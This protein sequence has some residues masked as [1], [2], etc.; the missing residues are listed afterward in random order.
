MDL[1]R[2]G[3]GKLAGSC[4]QGNEDSLFIKCGEL[5]ASQEGL[6]SMDLVE[7]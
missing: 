5:S 6:S 4:E 7:T 3:K 2:K 1:S